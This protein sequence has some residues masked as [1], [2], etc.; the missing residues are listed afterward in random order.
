MPELTGTELTSLTAET[1]E[2]L[3]DRLAVPEIRSALTRAEVRREVAAEHPGAEL[4]VE[5]E[6]PFYRRQGDALVEGIIDRLVLVIREGKPVAAHVLDYKTDAVPPG[7]LGRLEERTAL[8][9]P[10]LRA[11]REAVAES[12][13]IPAGSVRLTLLFLEAGRVVDVE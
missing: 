4:R 10:Q 3:Q 13:R 12:Y 8:Y 2:W 11:Y 6:L 7:N 1:W 5:R 9:A